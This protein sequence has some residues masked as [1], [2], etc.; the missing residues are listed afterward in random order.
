V[1]NGIAQPSTAFFLNGQK[2]GTIRYLEGDDAS[3]L[4]FFTSLLDFAGP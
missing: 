2:C 4:M 3:T 1:H